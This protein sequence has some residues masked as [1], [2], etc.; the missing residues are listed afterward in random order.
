MQATLS[1][2]TPTPIR[3]RRKTDYGPSWLLWLG[4]LVFLAL[5]FGVP[6]LWL[7]L[8]P[9]KNDNQ[10]LTEPALS[11]GNPANYL[12]AWNNLMAYGNSIVLNWA[13]NSIFYTLAS[14]VLSVVI[15][16]PA[17]YAF[18]TSNF[19]GRKLLMT[20]TL[21]TMILP[22][23]AMVLPLFLQMNLFRLV[24][25]PWAVIIPAAFYPFGV[26]L[27]Y[28]HF[29][30]ALPKDLLAAGRVDGCNEWQLFRYIG[31][32]LAS[33]LFALLS[34]LSFLGNWNNYFLPF[35]M[36]NDSDLFSL[37]VGIQVMATSTP[38]LNPVFAAENSTL[39]RPEAALVVLVL[40]VPVIIIFIIA[41]RFVVN[42]ALTGATKE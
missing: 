30:T 41:Q 13:R 39:K 31:L 40:V 14:V 10:L 22:G 11:L 27:S 8:A 29:A 21:I 1:T 25:T 23:S 16:V 32:P 20:L 35:V 18:A 33:T 42:G 24:D 28:V 38:M 26:Y 2:P 19:P 36:L 9:T 7:V 12:V 17:G 37:P 5:Y 15:S 34:F 4:V 3:K 6:I